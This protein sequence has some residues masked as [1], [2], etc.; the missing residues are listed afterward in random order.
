VRVVTPG[1][2]SSA[3]PE[4]L[5]ISEGN[6]CHQLR[7]TAALPSRHGWRVAASVIGSVTRLMTAR[8][9]RARLGRMSASDK[10]GDFPGPAA[11]TETAGQR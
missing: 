4:E 1:V 10:D 2:R 8:C 11:T 6:R 7:T 9:G 3:Q 5:A